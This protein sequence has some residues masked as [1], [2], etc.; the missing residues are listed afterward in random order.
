MGHELTHGFDDE[1]RQFDGNGNLADWWTAE[2]GKKFD[3]KADCEVK[4]YGN[5][6]AVDDV[7][8]NGKLTL[9]ENTADNGG[10][11]LAYMAFL[12]DAKRKNIDLQ[13]KAGR[14]H[15]AAAILPGIWPELVRQHP[16]GAAAPAGADRSALA[17]PV[18]RERR[19]AEHAGVRPGVRLQGRAADDAGRSLPRVVTGSGDDL[20]GDA[21]RRLMSRGIL[22]GEFVFDVHGRGNLHAMA[23]GRVQI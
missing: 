8:V 10:L 2:D 14:L 6:V 22:G 5:F 17:A 16:A 19:G 23:Q 20:D 21:L 1:G 12:A 13:Q 11:R 3:E 4:E 18:P 9:G 7:K 15:A